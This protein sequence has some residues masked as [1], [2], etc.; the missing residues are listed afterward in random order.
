LGF[1]AYY[2]DLSADVISKHWGKSVS[3]ILRKLSDNNYIQTNAENMFSASSSGL[4][5]AQRVLDLK[6]LEAEKKHFS[7]RWLEA[8]DKT[9]KSTSKLRDIQDT[10]KEKAE[11][12][13]NYREDRFLPWWL[14]WVHQNPVEKLYMQF[15][16]NNDL[17]KTWK[18]LWGGYEDWF[19]QTRFL[20]HMEKLHRIAFAPKGMALR[21]KYSDALFGLKIQ[22]KNNW[23]YIYLGYSF[24]L[25]KKEYIK[26][27]WDL[28]IANNDLEF[29]L[30]RQK[31]HHMMLNL[32]STPGDRTPFDSRGL[33]FK[34]L[35]YPLNFQYTVS[36][37]F[38]EMRTRRVDYNIAIP[39]EIDEKA[40]LFQES[41]I[42][43]LSKR[44]ASE[45]L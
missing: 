6:T 35:M 2:G 33:D 10:F 24:D 42:G 26:E 3:A 20:R 8:I 32:H 22:H 17:F 29:F 28:A 23:A 1:L 13:S 5:L 30:M 40:A 16:N 21:S 34:P 9:L 27:Y 14:Y 15:A 4:E 45:D 25:R 38:S 39:H 18:Q 11:A 37:Q 31:S 36:L 44:V 41:R 12:F 7:D 19:P 43:A